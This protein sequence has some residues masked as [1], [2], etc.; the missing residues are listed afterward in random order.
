MAQVQAGVVIRVDGVTKR[1]G[2]QVAVNAL[3]LAVPEGS[4]FGLLAWSGRMLVG[5]MY[6][7]STRHGRGSMCVGE[8]V[9]CPNRRSSTIG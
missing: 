1:Y 3:S 5:L 4:I 2:S 9:M 7:G 6:W 8:P